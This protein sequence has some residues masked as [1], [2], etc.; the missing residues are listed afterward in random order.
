MEDEHVRLEVVRV[1]GLEHRLREER[2][3]RVR[4]EDAH[5]KAVL[6]VGAAVRVDHV[7]VP[8]LEVGGDLPAQPVEVLLGDLG[9][10]VAPPDP[11][12]RAG[13]PHD[14]LVLRRAAGEAAGVDDEPAGV[15][16]DTFAAVERSRVELRRARVAED[17]TARPQAVHGESLL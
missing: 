13:L 8:L 12:F 10:H 15:R 16:E 11:V 9:V 14:E 1:G 2:V 5:R 3:V 4:G 17:A 6:R 7:D